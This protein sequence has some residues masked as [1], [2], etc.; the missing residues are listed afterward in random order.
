VKHDYNHYSQLRFV[1]RN[2][3]LPYL[4][5]ARTPNPGAFGSRVFTDPTCTP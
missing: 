5:Y 2:F 1:E 3:H 4:G